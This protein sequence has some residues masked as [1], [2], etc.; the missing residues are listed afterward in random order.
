MTAGRPTDY[1][2]EY[3]EQIEKFAETACPDTHCVTNDHF[4]DL[5]DCVEST[6]YEWAKKNPKF[7]KSFARA[8]AVA[9]RRMIDRGIDLSVMPKDRHFNEKIFAMVLRHKMGYD[10]KSY[11]TM[12]ELKSEKDLSKKAKLVLDAVAD[13]LVSIEEGEKLL[14]AIKSEMAIQSEAELRPIIE[15]LQALKKG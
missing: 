7:S 12:P 6:L 4:C 5:F 10:D 13:G 1:R 15:Q 14:N 2:E 8:R 9:R 11:V 3:C